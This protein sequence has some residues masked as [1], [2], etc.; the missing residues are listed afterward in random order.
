MNIAVLFGGIS[1]EREVSISSASKVV[2]ALRDKGHNVTTIDS[3]TGRLTSAQDRE[4]TAL[5]GVREQPTESSLLSLHSRSN[6]IAF[7][8]AMGEF[9][10]VFIALHGGSGEDGHV[11]ALLE[12]LGVPFTG[13][14]SISSGLAM[15]KDISK[16]LAEQGGVRTPSWL[17]NE[18]YFPTVAASLGLPVIVKPNT[19]GSSVGLQIVREE[20]DFSPAI[21]NAARYGEVMIETYVSGREFTVSVLD[22]TPLPVGEIIT[23]N[24][25]LFDYESKYQAAGAA[26]IFPAQIGADLAAELQASA[27]KIHHLFKLDGYSRSDF[28]VDDEGVVW[29][30]EVNTL[31]GL[32][33]QSL[34]PKA[35]ESAGISFGDFCERIVELALLKAGDPG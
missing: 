8:T 13:S 21:A 31:P 29:F 16:R 25:R 7:G 33:S 14:S 4:L 22:D 34:L 12:L 19:Q 26:E 23:D 32:T 35:L 27:L 18:T 28:L 6:A 11:Q 3:A 5:S 30:M 20:K 17:M 24:G 2:R 1:E 9:D 15:D 10:V